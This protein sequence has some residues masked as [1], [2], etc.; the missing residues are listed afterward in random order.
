MYKNDKDYTIK[1]SYEETN[2]LINPDILEKIS[3]SETQVIKE[4][5]ISSTGDEIN[6]D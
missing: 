2:D 6:L 1:E 3:A 5:S 4:L